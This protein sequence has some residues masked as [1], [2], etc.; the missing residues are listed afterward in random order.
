MSYPNGEDLYEACEVFWGDLALRGRTVES[1]LK[2]I[3][4]QEKCSD[5]AGRG[6][7]K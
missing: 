4:I 5:A 7:G 3:T 6:K 1:S 2:L